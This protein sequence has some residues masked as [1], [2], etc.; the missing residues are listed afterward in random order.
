VLLLAG[1]VIL[2]SQPAAANVDEQTALAVYVRARAADSVGASA[3]AVRGYAAALALAPQNETLAARALDQGLAAGDRGLALAAARALDAAGKL[4]VDGRLLLLGEAL[5]TRDWR[6]ARL[7]TDRIEEDEVFAFLTP[8]LRAWLAQGSGKGD[9]LAFLANL[10]DNPLAEAY[11]DE[12]RALLL[13]AEGKREQGVAA[14]TGELGD[15]GARASRLRIAAAAL[16]ARKGDR[17][18]ALAMLEGDAEPLVAARA[19]LAEGRKLG[20]EIAGPTAGVAELFVRIALDLNGQEVSGL[21]LAFARLATFLAPDNSET[22]IVTGELLAAS[23]QHEAALAALA[24]IGADDPFAGTAADNRIDLL[25]AA[26]RTEEALTRT[27]ATVE[28][29]PDAAPGWARLGDLLGRLKRHAEAADAYGKSLSLVR[30]GGAGAEREWALLLLQGS[31]LVDAGRWAEGKQ[32]LEASY[33]LAPEQALVLNYLGYSQLER[34]ENVAEAERLIREASRLQPDNAAITDSLGWAHFLRGDLPKAIEL[35][36]RAARGQP[37]DAAIKEHLGD[38][39][40]KA[41]R[42]FEARYAWQAALVYAE[43]NAADRLRAKVDT[44]LTPDLAAP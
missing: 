33:K 41:G 29:R 35:L 34:R 40:F 14:L 6:A 15:A 2:P 43:G 7:Q 42:R 11:A 5:R 25:V 32:A 31:A 16:L 18:K 19:A 12:Q 36:E 22:W 26:G 3:L 1:T 20:G 4:K 27:K 9:P 8:L 28:A 10:K 39:Y 21:A 13:L 30:R 24:A 38:A 44:G 17:A 37:A 23:G